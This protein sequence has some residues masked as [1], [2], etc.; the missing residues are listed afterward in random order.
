MVADRGFLE[1]PQASFPAEPYHDQ[2]WLPTSSHFRFIMEKM[3]EINNPEANIPQ[4]SRSCNF[5]AQ[6]RGML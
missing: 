1:E 2:F 3:E 5:T 6:S 4:D